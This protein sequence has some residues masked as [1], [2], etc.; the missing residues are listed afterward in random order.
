MSKSLHNGGS[1]ELV[2]DL[3]GHIVGAGETV[4][5]ED[6]DARTTAFIKNGSLVELKK[7]TP[8]PKTA[9]DDKNGDKK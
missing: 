1:V 4:E 5:V 2:Y 8:R 6:P 9:D 3:A 7:R